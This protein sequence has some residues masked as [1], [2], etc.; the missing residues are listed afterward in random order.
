MKRSAFDAAADQV[1]A[2]RSGPDLKSMCHAHGCPN[3]WSSSVEHLCR[4]HAEAKP[5]T[6]P[7]VTED[8]EWEI[9]EKARMRG[10]PLF[11]PEPVSSQRKR[12]IL[13]RLRKVLTEPKDDHAWLARLRARAASGERMS[14]AQKHA[15]HECR[16]IDIEHRRAA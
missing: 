8:L 14:A 10:M 2:D 16:S 4:W 13:R 3:R 9:T 12:E 11:A 7:R 15:L 1:A 6:W 5:E